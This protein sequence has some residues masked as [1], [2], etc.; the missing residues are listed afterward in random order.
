MANSFS[1]PNISG[2][3]KIRIPSKF[4][5]SKWANINK[6]KGSQD[7]QL[8]LESDEEFHSNTG[9]AVKNTPHIQ[10]SGVKR[11]SIQNGF[12]LKKCNKSK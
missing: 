5:K 12:S 11:L 1:L 6:M 10:I 8:L 7:W 2:T 3:C 9:N 4:F